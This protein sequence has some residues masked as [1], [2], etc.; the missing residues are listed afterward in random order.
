MSKFKVGDRVKIVRCIGNGGL[1]LEDRLLAVGEEYVIES[2]NPNCFNPCRDNYGLVGRSF[3]V[4]DVELELVEPKQF[5]KSDLKD[6][7]VVEYRRGWMELVLGEKTVDDTG[8]HSLCNFNNNLMNDRSRESDIMRVYTVNGDIKDIG[9]IFNR[10]FLT[11]LWERK[12]EPDYIEMTV[13]EIEEKLGYKIKVV[14]DNSCQ[15]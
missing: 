12:E 13:A 7:M 1:S 14:G 11:L 4:Y 8:S 2:V 3:V 10:D 15:K 9:C 6:G 5:T